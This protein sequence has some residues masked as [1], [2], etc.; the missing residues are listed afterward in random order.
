[1]YGLYVTKDLFFASR[2]TA[3]ARGMGAA[4]HVVPSIE[5]LAAAPVDADCSLVLLDLDT[6][7]VDL[8]AVV[9]EAR[10]RGESGLPVIA[11]GSHVHEARLEAARQAACDLVLTRGQFDRQATEILRTHLGS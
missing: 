8:A 3:A 6:P 7:G 4:M 5:E 9:A 10:R 1:M 2:I 11:F